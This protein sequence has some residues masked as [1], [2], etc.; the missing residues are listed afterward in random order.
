MI[1]LVCG[2]RDFKYTEVVETALTDMLLG[3]PHKLTHVITGMAPGADLLARDWAIK[4]GIQPV[5]CPA[6]WGA[7]PRSGARNAGTRRNTAM[8]ELNPS[9]VIAFPGGSGTADMINQTKVAI[10]VGR[11]SPVQLYLVSKTGVYN[12]WKP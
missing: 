4:R 8:L 10:R 11:P 3:C 6:L 1:W 5:D 2:G 7:Y 9:W 12:R